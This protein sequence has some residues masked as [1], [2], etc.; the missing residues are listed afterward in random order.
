MVRIQDETDPDD[1]RTFDDVRLTLTD[2]SSRPKLIIRIPPGEEVLIFYD[3][4]HIL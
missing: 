1:L 4:I 2:S 3:Q